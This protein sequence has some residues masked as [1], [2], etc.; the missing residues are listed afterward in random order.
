MLEE[1]RKMFTFGYDSYIKYA[2]PLDELDPIH[3]SGKVFFHCYKIQDNFIKKYF[4]RPR[5]RLR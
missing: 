1:T 3:C 5:S 4:N 2:F